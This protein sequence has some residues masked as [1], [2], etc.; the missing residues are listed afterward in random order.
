VDP[1][2]IENAHIFRTWGWSVA[3]IISEHLKRVLESEHITGVK[4]VEV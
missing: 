3:L 1:A 4:F 2:K